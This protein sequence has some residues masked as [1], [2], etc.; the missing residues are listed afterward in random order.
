MSGFACG[1]SLGLEIF[2]ICHH[3]RLQNC[4]TDVSLFIVLLLLSILKPPEAPLLGCP[5]QSLRTFVTFVAA[6]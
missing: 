1:Y 5:N 6:P 2:V 3:Q 4:V